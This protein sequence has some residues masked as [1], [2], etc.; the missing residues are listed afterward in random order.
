MKRSVLE[1]SATLIGT[2]IGAGI[3]GIPY[4]I[5]QSGFLIGLFYILF[6]GLVMLT[7]NLY[8][9]E[10][11]LQGAIL[12]KLTQGDPQKTSY[13]HFCFKHLWSTNSLL[14]RRRPNSFRFI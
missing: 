3:L 5:A 14:N 4:V 7:L 12:K 10:V 2:T 8:I 1:A 6:L 11:V 13:H 9:G